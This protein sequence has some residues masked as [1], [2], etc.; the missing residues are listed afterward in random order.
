MVPQ[1]RR[2]SV[3]VV[4]CLGVAVYSACSR[5]PDSDIF[6][7]LPARTEITA[8]GS[9]PSRVSGLLDLEH[10]YWLR[11]HMSR[12]SFQHYAASLDMECEH[13]SYRTDCV[14]SDVGSRL[15]RES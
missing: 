13:L 12:D 9:Q 10:D 7:F 8:W 4:V 2:V 3:L 15:W 5:R 1:L 6:N 11:A 14:R